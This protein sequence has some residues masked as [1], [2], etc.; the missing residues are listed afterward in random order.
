MPRPS[1][2]VAAA[3]VA[4]VLAAMRRAA[5]RARTHKPMPLSDSNAAFNAAV[6]HAYVGLGA[7]L[8][9]AAASVRAAIV[10]I[11]R[12][13]GVQLL[14]AS[15]L[16]GSAP[17]DAGGADYV[18]AVIKLQTHG[19]CIALLHGLQAIE[20]H[21]GRLR[22]Y[23]NAPRTLDLDILLYGDEVW[24]SSELTV[25]HPRMAQRAFVLRPLAEIAPALVSAA[26]L[27]AVRA[28]AVW[29]LAQPPER[30]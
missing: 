14:A 13:Q 21:A 26:Q 1:A 27:E 6:V 17:V 20:T 24:N 5:S 9:D 22:P 19:S 12:M 4:K 28:Q 23:R 3:R 30:V 16:Y 7:N 2:A 10:E 25:P 15:S 29:P 8:G 11:S 18:N